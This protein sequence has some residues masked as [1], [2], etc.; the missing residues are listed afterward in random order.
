MH[1]S[2]NIVY[3]NK[4]AN[5]PTVIQKELICLLQALS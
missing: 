3:H 5:K 2:V 4:L 1:A